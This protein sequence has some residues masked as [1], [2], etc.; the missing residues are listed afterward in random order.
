M[1]QPRLE[2]LNAPVLNEIMQRPHLSGSDAALTA[3]TI[4]T[5]PLV[6]LLAVPILLLLLL[7]LG[8]LIPPLYLP[9]CTRPTRNSKSGVHD[10][11]PQE[12]ERL[13][14]P[15]IGVVEIRQR[16]LEAITQDVLALSPLP[17][18]SRLPSNP[19]RAPPP[20]IGNSIRIY[21]ITTHPNRTRH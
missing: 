12:L 18:P 20:D 4:I 10:R 17:P 19:L 16:F 13:V 7:L 6:F 8:L 15:D 2:I 1:P 11:V 9:L 21:E 3:C 5:L 14:E